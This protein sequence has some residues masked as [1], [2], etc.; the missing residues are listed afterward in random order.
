MSVEPD[1]HCCVYNSW[2]VLSQMSTVHVFT[3]S[4]DLSSVLF[5]FGFLPNV[6]PFP[7]LSHICY[8]LRPSHPP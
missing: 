4:Q 1:V 2:I 3:L 5:P 7:Y 6:A 8:I